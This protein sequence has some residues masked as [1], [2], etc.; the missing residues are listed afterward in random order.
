MTTTLGYASGSDFSEFSMSSHLSHEIAQLMTFLC[1]C[2]LVTLLM[3]PRRCC[4]WTR[5]REARSSR[6][7]FVRSYLQGAYLEIEATTFVARL[8]MSC[9][10]RHWCRHMYQRWG[11]SRHHDCKLTPSL[12]GSQRSVTGERVV[13]RTYD[14]PCTSV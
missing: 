8:V 10:L 5:S 13:L 2:R 1:L 12:L 3:S 14:R 7:L 6:Q 4:A 9:L 11:L